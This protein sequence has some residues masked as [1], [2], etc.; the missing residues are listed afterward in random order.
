MHSGNEP[1]IATDVSKLL[2]LARNRSTEGR[3]ALVSAIGDLIDETERQFSPHEL[4]LVN[5][6]L[7]K[8]IHDVAGP[9]RKS[10][11]QKLAH[12]RS[13]PTDVI[14]LLANEDIDIAS[15]ILQHSELLS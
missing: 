10:L 13:A 15:P 7:K 9:I 8:L 11:A 1:V 3:S 4:A 12:T 14:E 2:D 5:D 6:I